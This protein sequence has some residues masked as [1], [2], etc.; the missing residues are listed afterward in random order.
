L[1]I[2]WNFFGVP[3]AAHF[4]QLFKSRTCKLTELT[5][6]G[7]FST[8]CETATLHSS[9]VSGDGSS[10][11]RRLG[12]AGLAMVAAFLPRCTHIK[13]LNVS[14][15]KDKDTDEPDDI[16]GVEVL[17]DAVAACTTLTELDVSLASGFCPEGAVVFAKAITRMRSLI[18]LTFSGDAETSQPVQMGRE[19]GEAHFEHE[20]FG[21]S[22]AEI[23]A[24]FLPACSTLT[25]L[26]I[27][28]NGICSEGMQSI[29]DRLLE[30]G[31][32]VASLDV[33]VNRMDS[34]A[35]T[36]FAAVLRRN[37]T[38]TAM[39]M[40]GNRLT[41][42]L[43][44][45]NPEVQE[46]RASAAKSDSHYDLDMEGLADLAS[47]L[48][49]NR[50]LT[51]ID[52]SGMEIRGRGCGHLALAVQSNVA[53]KRLTF[54]G[55]Y[56]DCSVLTLDLGMEKADFDGSVIYASGACMLASF[57][58]KCIKLQSLNI[59]GGR[60]G[61]D[62]IV[63]I[64]KILKKNKFTVVS[65]DVSNNWLGPL[66]VWQISEALKT[67]SK[68]KHLIM[69]KNSLGGTAHRRIAR[70]LR[71][72]RNLKS[73]DLQ[74]GGL[75]ARNP[76]PALEGGKLSGKIPTPSRAGGRKLLPAI[77]LNVHGGITPVPFLTMTPEDPDERGD[78]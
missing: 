34:R 3:G 9:T 43:C 68:V 24:A 5:F 40:S 48:K 21:P 58:P 56:P 29:A 17:A 19:F 67:N 66:G 76:L 8:S 63:H 54:D 27:P 20:G 57:L 23:L 55:G 38:I 6:T 74:D 22:G 49:G 33:S 52:I 39:N 26:H 12:Q 42:G 78:L 11:L 77:E 72:N 14:K 13:T 4:A 41:R 65:L 10:Q 2:S 71:K 50:T 15:S 32:A 44:K 18:K 47:A 16:S 61:A 31:C 36:P 28:D 60:L 51:D 59:S 75:P 45:H 35:C 1:D 62:G 46:R 73:F 7:D 25:A 64:A 53:I 70:V 30:P 37:T 69:S